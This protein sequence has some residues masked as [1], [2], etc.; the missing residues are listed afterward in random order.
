MRLCFLVKIQ[1]NEAKTSGIMF[2][3]NLVKCWLINL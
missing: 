3:E 1:Y 2:L